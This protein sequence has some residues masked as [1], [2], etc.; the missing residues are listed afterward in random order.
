MKKTFIT[1]LALAGVAM[2]AETLLTMDFTTLTGHTGKSDEP[3]TL[4]EGWTAG[5][6]Q[7]ANQPYYTFGENGAVVGNG[8]KQNYLTYNLDI[9]SQGDYSITFT[10]YNGETDTNNVFFLSS[11]TYSIAMGNSYSS[12]ANIYVGTL[13]GA[14]NFE[15]GK[16]N[17]VSFQTISNGSNTGFTIPTVVDQS[18]EFSV[19]GD[20]TYTLTLSGGDMAIKVTNSAGKSYECTLEGMDNVT[21]DTIGFS[22][23]ASQY[24]AGIKNITVTN[25][26]EPATATL[27]LLAL[28]GLCARRRRA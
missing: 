15:S 21:F 26:P 1:L 12:N 13:T 8:W 2:G 18:E 6:W 14:V 11:D 28:A 4:P 23:D 9:A 10:L 24:K 5:Y 22:T 20:L 27:S 7:G 25:I 3:S 16:E 19:S 17:F